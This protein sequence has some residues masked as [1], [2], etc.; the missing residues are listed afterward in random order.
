VKIVKVDL[1][2]VQ[3]ISENTNRECDESVTVI[4][5]EL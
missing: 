1:K 4:Q 3:H 5:D 2:R